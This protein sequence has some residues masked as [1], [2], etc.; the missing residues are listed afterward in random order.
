MACKMVT[1]GGKGDVVVR[2]P[3]SHQSGRGSNS[4]V[5]AIWGLR[6]LLVLFFALRGFYAGTPAFP[7]LRN[8]HFHIPNRYGTHGQTVC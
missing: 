8:L 6:L 1:Q 5:D 4:R 3:A 7:L 2:A